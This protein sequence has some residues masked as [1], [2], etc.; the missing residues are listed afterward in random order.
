MPAS[1]FA[2]SPLPVSQRELLGLIMGFAA[3]ESASF[4]QAEFAIVAAGGGPSARG[5]ARELLSDLAIRDWIE[6]RARAADGE[7]H[8][9]ER[10]RW[11]L[12]LAAEDNWSESRADSVRYALT[13]KGRTRL[14]PR[15]E[16]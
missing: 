6:L 10:R 3:R 11:E 4:S 12:E 16:G 7:E 1:A 15:L 8:R 5:L 14:L 9:I 2:D 13:A